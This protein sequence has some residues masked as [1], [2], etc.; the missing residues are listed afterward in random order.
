MSLGGIRIWI[1]TKTL[2]IRNTDSR[3]T[4]LVQ[5]WVRYFGLISSLQYCMTDTGNANLT[6]YRTQHLVKRDFANA[7]IFVKEV[8]LS[9]STFVQLTKQ[10]RA[11]FSETDTR[12]SI[13]VPIKRKKISIA[14]YPYTDQSWASRFLSVN[15]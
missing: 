14:S 2:R 7:K 11:Y 12:Y 3:C 13:P 15:P 4:V 1:R 10:K 8:L 5:I 6:R 9:G